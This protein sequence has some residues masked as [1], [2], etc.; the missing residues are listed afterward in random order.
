MEAST[1]EHKLGEECED[2]ESREPMDGEIQKGKEE[3]HC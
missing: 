3:F 1:D 2:E